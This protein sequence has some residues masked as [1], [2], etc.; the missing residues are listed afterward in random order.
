MVKY[1]SSGKM[2]Y[3]LNNEPKTTTRSKRTGRTNGNGTYGQRRL[4]KSF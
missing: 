3:L 1:L 4:N 2:I